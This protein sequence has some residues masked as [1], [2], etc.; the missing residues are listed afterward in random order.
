[1]NKIELVKDRNARWIL[2]SSTK[3]KN[4]YRI[5]RVYID[6]T[7][8]KPS[9]YHTE[10]PR[11]VYI[12]ADTTYPKRVFAVVEQI[13]LTIKKLRTPRNYTR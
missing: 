11:T 5:L 8:V 12:S 7:L 4:N 3:N 6:N 13:P 2:P 9:E 10:G 1:M